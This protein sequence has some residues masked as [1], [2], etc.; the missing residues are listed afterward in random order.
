MQRRIRQQIPHLAGLYDPKDL[1][2]DPGANPSGWAEGRAAIAW[3]P[4]PE[5]RKALG[6]AG[7]ILPKAPSRET[8][9]TVNSK[10]FRSRFPCD[11]PGAMWVSSWEE[12][13]DWISNFC[14][15]PSLASLTWVLKPAFGFAGRGLR[16]F[17]P[18]EVNGA[19]GEG[20]RK[21]L[22]T[23]FSSGQGAQLE[24]WVERLFDVGF[25]AWLEPSGKLREGEP[26]LQRCD[27][28]GKWLATRRIRPGEL[29]AEEERMLKDTLQAVARELSQEGYFGPFG[30]DGFVYQTDS[31]SRRLRAL[32]EVNARYSMGWALGCEKIRKSLPE[33]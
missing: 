5:A 2:L 23:I 28:G 30:L 18:S 10:A 9:R 13:L 11:L 1:V 20:L 19:D 25:H 27:P 31:A 7:A 3:C 14:Q 4:T 21:R 16:R 24:P 33:G 12:F 26:T 6:E 15:T 22:Q 17:T 8:L 29:R 32:S